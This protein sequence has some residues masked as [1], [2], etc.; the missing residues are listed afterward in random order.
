ML[1]ESGAALD[2]LLRQGVVWGATLAMRKDVLA[3]TLPF[4]EGMGQAF[5]HDYWIPMVLE[6]LSRPALIPHDTSVA[7]IWDW[8]GP[9]HHR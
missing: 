5:G 7:R 4:P 9:V 1:F 8:S 2:V 3:A 6:G